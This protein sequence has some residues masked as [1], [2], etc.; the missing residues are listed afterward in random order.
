MTAAPGGITVSELALR[1]DALKPLSSYA[2]RNPGKEMR[3]HVLSSAEY[4]ARRGR[5]IADTRVAIA[6]EAIQMT[7][8]ATLAHDDL[9]DESDQRR[10]LPSVP[11]MFGAPLAGAGGAAFLGHALALISRCGPQAVLLASEAA[12]DICKGQM[13]ELKALY[14]YERTVADYMKAIEGKTGA[15]FRLAAE[16]G[17]IFGGAQAS[18]REALAA[19]GEAIGV[20]HQIIDD[21]LDL[22]A[23]PMDTGKPAGVDLRNGNYTLPVIYALE[24]RSELMTV[25]RNASDT[26]CAIEAIRETCAIARSVDV[27]THWLRRARSAVSGLPVA[28]G[29]LAIADA[30]EATMEKHY[31]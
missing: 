2:L 12:L 1:T 9:M 6:A 24:E 17:A 8:L 11:A 10:G 15:G 5:G 25:F 28:H 18:E 7:H 16:L 30:D 29:L 23:D 20:A 3:A 4:V 19:Y 26:R 21:V 14:D 31:A 27:A 22:T 13:L